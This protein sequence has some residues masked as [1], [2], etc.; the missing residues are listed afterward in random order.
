MT[1]AVQ[2][3]LSAVIISLT[4]LVSV[5][6]IQIFQILHELRLTLK[7]ANRILDNAESLSE[8]AAKPITAVNHFFSDVKSLVKDT[9]DE[10][11]DSLPDKVIPPAN[12]TH[13][14]FHKRF[15]HRSG[16]PLRPS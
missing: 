10:I 16:L 7:K 4:V 6:G 5:V 1:L 14:P 8:S 12:E 2:I 11:I 15:F 13:N 3:L 9:E